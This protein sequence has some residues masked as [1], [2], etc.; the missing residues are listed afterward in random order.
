[1]RDYCPYNL[2]YVEVGMLRLGRAS[3]LGVAY[4]HC[5]KDV[6]MLSKLDALKALRSFLK[7]PCSS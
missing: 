4:P 2:V 5:I 7:K 6:F 3:V 1:M